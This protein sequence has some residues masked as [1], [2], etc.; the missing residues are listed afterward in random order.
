MTLEIGTDQGG[1]SLP[2]S[3]QKK[4]PSQILSISAESIKLRSLT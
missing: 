4:F 1:I 3:G 2:R